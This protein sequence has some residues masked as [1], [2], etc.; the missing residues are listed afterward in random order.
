MDRHE[1][2][3]RL[4]P[5]LTGAA[6]ALALSTPAGAREVTG[7]VAQT[8]RVEDLT[9]SDGRLPVAPEGKSLTLTVNGTETPLAAGDWTGDIVLTVSSGIP[10]KYRE[11]PDHQ[12]RTALYVADGKV[13]S[14]RS[15]L[16]AAGSLQLEPG[17]ARDARIIS[18]GD[19][20]NGV[21]ATG[22]GSYTLDRPMIDMIG[23]GGNDFAGFGAAIMATGNAEL[24]VNRP[25]IRTRGA[26]RTALFTGGNAT[27]RVND[28][29]IEVFN[30]TLPPDYT[31]TIDVGRMMEVP[32]MLGLSGNVRASNLVDNGVS[33]R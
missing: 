13:D 18:R 33:V 20:F 27:M 30:G 28:A 5:L 23:N 12:F 24:T 6:I 2:R 22:K 16:P 25:I 8:V 9:L 4:A 26:V 15:V 21:I 32:W 31:F 19:L 3:H 14:D 1:C 7:V 11:L 17:I 10:V 29:D